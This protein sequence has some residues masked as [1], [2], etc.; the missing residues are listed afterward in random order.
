MS[1]FELERVGK[2]YGALHKRVARSDVSSRS[3]R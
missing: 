2:C 1:L 3:R